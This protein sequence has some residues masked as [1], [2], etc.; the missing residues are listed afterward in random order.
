MSFEVFMQVWCLQKSQLWW[1]Q[2]K[3]GEKKPR[4]SHFRTTLLVVRNFRTTQPLCENAFVPISKKHALGPFSKSLVRI[5]QECE[6]CANLV[7][8]R[9]WDK[10]SK[11][12]SLSWY[13]TGM[14]N[15]RT[16]QGV[17]RNLHFLFT[18]HSH[19]IHY[20]SP[21]IPSIFSSFHHQ[22]PPNSSLNTLNPSLNQS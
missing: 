18:L 17:V 13:S 4:L 20:S 14:R 6:P 8:I 15:F 3:T 1:K 5:S 12:C 21:P 7:R 16:T 2:G 22:K 10:F 9:F 19:G 11:P